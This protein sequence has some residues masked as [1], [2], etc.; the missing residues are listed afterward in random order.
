MAIITT[1]MP[2]FNGMPYL[3]DALDS[4]LRQSV[5][6]ITCIVVDGQ[7]TDG[8]WEYLQTV[9]RSSSRPRA[10]PSGPWTPTDVGP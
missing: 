10:M 5:T 1:L 6:D 9:K 3:P 7:S 2:V 4:I 8:S